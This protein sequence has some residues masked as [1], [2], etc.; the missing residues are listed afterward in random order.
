MPA[1]LGMPMISAGGGRCDVA[2]EFSWAPEGVDTG[3][4][5][6]ARVYGWRPDSPAD[7]PEDPGKFWALVGVGRKS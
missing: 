6:V 3:Q 2:E 5:N 7:V 1:L 4:A